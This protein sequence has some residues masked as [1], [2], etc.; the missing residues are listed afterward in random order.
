MDDEKNRALY[1]T[2]GYRIYAI[3]YGFE[4]DLAKSIRKAILIDYTDY[5]IAA[6][7]NVKQS[8]K[9]TWYVTLDGKKDFLMLAIED[10]QITA[11]EPIRKYLYDNKDNNEA[12]L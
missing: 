6:A 2:K 8:N 12:S 4:K 5:D 9:D 7:V 1:D 11:G 3:R 10:D